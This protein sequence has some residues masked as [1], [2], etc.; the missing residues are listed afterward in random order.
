MS[1]VLGP[2]AML[3]MLP[4]PVLA[5]LLFLFIKREFANN[6]KRWAK[7][8][9]FLESSH[10]FANKEDTK[11]ELTNAMNRALGEVE[12]E[13]EHRIK[14]GNELA[15]ANNEI[16]NLTARVTALEMMLRK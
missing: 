8:E 14:T 4:A 11:T 5:G 9:A 7:V 16:K 10:K 15:V 2:E 13:R 3:L 1:G 6:D 12:K